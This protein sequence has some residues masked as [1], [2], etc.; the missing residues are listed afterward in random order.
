MRNGVIFYVATDNSTQQMPSVGSFVAILVFGVPCF[1]IA[2]ILY[3][4]YEK[5]GK[6]APE[7]QRSTTP[8]TLLSKCIEEVSTKTST[9]AHKTDAL[10]VECQRAKQVQLDKDRLWVGMFY[11]DLVLFVITSFLVAFSFAA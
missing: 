3:A 2:G 5:R 11:I 1:V 9:T 7:W 10:V 8:E 6:I 4:D